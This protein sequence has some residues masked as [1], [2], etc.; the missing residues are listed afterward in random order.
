MRSSANSKQSISGIQQSDTTVELLVALLLKGQQN[1]EERRPAQR[2]VSK[3][4]L[5]IE[6]VASHAGD[7]T[8]L[9]SGLSSR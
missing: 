3:A 4:H 9:R 1:D 7:M 2:W 8:F 5:S 6:Y